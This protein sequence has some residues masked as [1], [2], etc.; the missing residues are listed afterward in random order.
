M[1]EEEKKESHSRA[2]SNVLNGS[3]S[4]DQ[5]QWIRLNGSDS[6]DQTQ[7]IKLNG[8]TSSSSSVPLFLYSSVSTTEKKRTLAASGKLGEDVAANS[9]RT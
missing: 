5:T 8:S 9:R 2:C 7:R 4:T 3:D 6:T 1:R